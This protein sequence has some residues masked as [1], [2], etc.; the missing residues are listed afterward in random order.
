M[1]VA[2]H[3]RTAANA[4]GE[5]L[6]RRD[7][8]LD[9]LGWRQAEAIG[10]AIDSPS[11]VVSSPLRRCRETASVWGLP[12]VVDERVI[13]LDYGELEG[14]P[15]SEVSP[16]TWAAWRADPGWRPPA[17]ETLEELTARVGAALADLA[18]EAAAGDVV[19]V[20]HVSPIKAAVSWALGVGA[21][22]SWRCFVAQASITRVATAGGRPSLHSFND[23]SHLIDID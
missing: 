11:R 18:E 7:P 2:R 8:G 10:A 15:V 5:L 9:E 3:G 19:V 22:I 6:G 14:T 16:A 4:A 12:V 23:I 1:I 20:S 13:E 17:G 21:E